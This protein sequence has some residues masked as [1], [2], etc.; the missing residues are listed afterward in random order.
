[1]I[2]E[3]LVEQSFEFLLERENNT[4]KGSIPV[5]TRRVGCGIRLG[6]RQTLMTH[7]SPNT[8]VDVDVP[9]GVLGSHTLRRTVQDRFGSETLHV[10]QAPALR[11]VAR[12]HTHLHGLATPIHELCRASH[13]VAGQQR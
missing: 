8:N 6:G 5:L 13:A 10:A 7:E 9:P 12:W 11:A 1:M 4:P 2:K 3:A